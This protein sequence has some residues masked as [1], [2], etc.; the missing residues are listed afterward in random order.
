MFFYE[1]AENAPLCVAHHRFSAVDDTMAT[2]SA[3][4][5]NRVAPRQMTKFYAY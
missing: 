3:L 4:C 1:F 2:L 5:W